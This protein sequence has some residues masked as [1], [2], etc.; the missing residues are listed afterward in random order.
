MNSLAWVVAPTWADAEWSVLLEYHEWVV[1][2]LFE[3]KKGVLPT[4]SV[5]ME[6]DHQMRT[7]WVEMQRNDKATLTEAVRRCR[8][9]HADLF[10]DLHSVRVA[11]SSGKPE[12]R[13]GTPMDQPARKRGRK[14]LERIEKKDG[15]SICTF[16]NAGKC[17]YGQRCK[18]L[19]VCNVRGCGQSHAA[20]DV[21]DL[22]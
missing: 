2:K 10:T 4:V 18:F 19:H 7:K 13:P 11:N 3:K 17:T 21:H 15:I 5:I 9:E 16:Y 6:A 14:D 1:L 20:C 8:A 22:R 12:R